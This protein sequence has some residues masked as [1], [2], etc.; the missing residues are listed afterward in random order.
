MHVFFF[1]L[2]GCSRQ[3]DVAFI[4]DLSGSVE[5]NNRLIMEFA[6]RVAYGLDFSLDRARVA[7]LA[8]ADQVLRQF[9]LNTYQVSKI[10]I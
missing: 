8:F 9:Y 1:Y 10:F 7:T 5:E 2:L 4:L 3:L 6:R